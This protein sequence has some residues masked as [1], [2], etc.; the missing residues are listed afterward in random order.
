MEPATHDLPGASVSTLAIEPVPAG[1]RPA[2]RIRP[3][4][5]LI[6]A[7]L[8]MALWGAMVQRHAAHSAHPATLP[9]PTSPAAIYLSLMVM[10][11]GLVLYVWRVGL[12]G[13]ATTLR[14][15]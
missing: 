2:F 9:R 1:P 4:V 10:E 6:A 15:L 5:V 12:R 14:D 11:W 7:F 3:T 8:V 13:S